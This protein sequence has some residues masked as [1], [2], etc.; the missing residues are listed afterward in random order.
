MSIGFQVVGSY[1]WL[2][3]PCNS[4]VRPSVRQ[5]PETIHM[6]VQG[7]KRRPM[8]LSSSW[9]SLCGNRCDAMEVEDVVA[10]QGVMDSIDKAVREIARATRRAAIDGYLGSSKAASTNRSGDIQKALDVVA[11]DLMKRH[12]YES[13]AVSFMA[14]EEEDE[15]L[16]CPISNGLTVVFD[17]LDGSRNIDA[18]Y[19]IRFF[20]SY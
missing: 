16:I 19:V 9:H 3:G 18:S 14:S 20:I 11:N 2:P 10:V 12:L 8:S 5:R 15:P 6:S 7:A 17:P 4:I 1:S 13:N